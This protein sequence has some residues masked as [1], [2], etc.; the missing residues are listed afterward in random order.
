MH[1]LSLHTYVAIISLGIA[2]VT[3]A[4]LIHVD[5]FFESS[6]PFLAPI[7]CHQVFVTPQEL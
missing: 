7:V 5:S 3:L 6:H 4:L 1:R 2:I